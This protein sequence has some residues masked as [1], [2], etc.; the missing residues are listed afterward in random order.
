MR[1]RGAIPGSGQQRNDDSSPQRQ[2]NV[3]LG[4]GDAIAERRDSALG[5][6]LDGGKCR[7]GSPGAGTDAEQD[8]RVHFEQA[9]TNQDADKVRDEGRD[10]QFQ[11]DRHFHPVTQ[12]A[13]QEGAAG[14][15]KVGQFLQRLAIHVGVG[16]EHIHALGWN[17]EE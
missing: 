2:E 4:I 11:C 12:N 17:I 15:R 1:L 16:D 3:A 7:R 14:E 13:S 8:P 9:M 10:A 6:F 5:G